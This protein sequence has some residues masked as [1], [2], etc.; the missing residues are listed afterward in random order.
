[1]KD[2][3][4]NHSSP[5]SEC[6]NQEYENYIQE[7]HRKLQIA[8]EERKRSEMETKVLEH[9]VGLLLNQEKLAKRKFESTKSKLEDLT[10]KKKIIYENQ[11]LLKFYR[12]SRDK[13]TQM[14]KE[15]NRQRRE[16]LKSAKSSNHTTNRTASCVNL[17][18]LS[19]VI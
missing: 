2:L 12:D 18:L 5:N 17:F 10:Q 4:Q 13:E 15:K 14:L 3:Y 1:M 7:L 8:R 16:T 6:L 19:R 11:N 9:R